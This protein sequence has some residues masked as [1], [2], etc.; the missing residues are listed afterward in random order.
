MYWQLRAILLLE[1]SPNP[2]P[3]LS[4]GYIDGK[5]G[6]VRPKSKAMQAVQKL[7]QQKNKEALMIPLIKAKYYTHNYSVKVMTVSRDVERSCSDACKISYRY[8]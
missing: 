4:P 6:H 2:T 3:P 7:H 8:N 5:L 1:Q